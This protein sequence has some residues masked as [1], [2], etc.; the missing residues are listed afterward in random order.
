MRD[1]MVSEKK[2]KS[3][4]SKLIRFFEGSR[5]KWKKKT[6]QA[7]YQIKLLRKKIKYLERNKQ[8]Y[9]EYSKNL[10]TQLQQMKDKEKRM[11]GE[12]NRLKKNL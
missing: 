6:K 7:K 10:E 11:Q 4:K 9:K 5:N 12:I 2:Y 3:P 8:E 1:N